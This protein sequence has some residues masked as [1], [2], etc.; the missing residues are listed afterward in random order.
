MEFL[1]LDN[2][3]APLSLTRREDDTPIDDKKIE[4]M[5]REIDVDHVSHVYCLCVSS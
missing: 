3:N 5:F 4:D 1:C 2:P